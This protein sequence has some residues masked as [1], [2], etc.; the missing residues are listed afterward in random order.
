MQRPLKGAFTTGNGGKSSHHESHAEVRTSGETG[1]PGPAP[2]EGAQAPSP[3]RKLSLRPF[4]R[5]QVA[6]AAANGEPSDDQ[7]HDSL[8][9]QSRTASVASKNFRQ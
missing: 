8:E 1:A 2:R 7:F 5:Q 4:R 6:A 9:L 3:K